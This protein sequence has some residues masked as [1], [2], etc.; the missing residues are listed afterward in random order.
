M[1]TRYHNPKT[2]ETVKAQNLDEA[3]KV[4]KK[5]EPKPATV[6]TI[7]DPVVSKPVATTGTKED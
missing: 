2:G 1:K 4:F 7:T 6:G 5:E 3:N